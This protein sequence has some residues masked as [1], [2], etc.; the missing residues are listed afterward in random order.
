M[1]T[2]K[3]KEPEKALENKKEKPK[4]WIEKT[5]EAIDDAAEKIHKSETYRK[6]D[7]SMEKATKSLF[8]KA[9]RFWGKSEQYFKSRD[10]K[11]DQK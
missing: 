2:D 1:E 8:R 7:Q 11:K 10:K 5:E 9:G 6:V 3:N 4:S